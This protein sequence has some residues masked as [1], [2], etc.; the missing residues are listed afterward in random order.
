[1][2]SQ[3]RIAIIFTVKANVEIDSSDLLIHNS[4]GEE[5]D[6]KQEHRPKML[7]PKLHCRTPENSLLCDT[8]IC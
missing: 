3:D 8:E 2:N 4:T 6:T 5:M 7:T 1:M